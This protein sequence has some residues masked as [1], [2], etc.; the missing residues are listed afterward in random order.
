MYPEQL[1]E[2]R[3]QYP[4]TQFD[5]HGRVI[6][7][8]P[9]DQYNTQQANPATIPS[10]VR[11]YSQFDPTTGTWVRHTN[12]D[13]VPAQ[14]PVQAASQGVP[15]NF[16]EWLGYTPAG[17]EGATWEMG[18]GNAQSRQVMRPLARG[19]SRDISAAISPRDLG[20]GVTAQTTGSYDYSKTHG[21]ENP[22][23]PLTQPGIVNP[24]AR[25][26]AGY[27]PNNPGITPTQNV[28]LAVSH[29]QRPTTVIPDPNG[30]IAGEIGQPVPLYE[31]TPNF[32]FRPEDKY[33]PER[34]GE[35]L[36]KSVG[37]AIAVPGEIALTLLA[38]WTRG[39]SAATGLG[40][41][42]AP[43]LALSAPRAAV[44]ARTGSRLNNMGEAIGRYG[45]NF[46]NRVGG[47]LRREH[48][49]T[50]NFTVDAA[51]NVQATSP[52]TTN[53]ISDAL[54]NGYQNVRGWFTR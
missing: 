27:D 50:A 51:G 52:Y 18:R 28:P 37:K 26:L 49:P 4:N 53:V 44:A 17:F 5:G 36:N 19:D 32:N 39:A 46:Y 15:V 33:T 25:N 47:F 8:T 13:A 42:V 20:S 9:L 14:S 29:A 6:G 41:G 11:T 21:N 24:P 23:A 22:V 48:T 30:A 2:L 31:P 38:P 40:L 3:A 54:R 10:S 1:R 7:G 12:G 16:N 34:A 35:L 43:R 45:K